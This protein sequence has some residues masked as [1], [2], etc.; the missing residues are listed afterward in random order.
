MIAPEIDPQLSWAKVSYA[1]VRG[2]IETQWQKSDGKVDLQ[3]TIPA[4]TTATV[5]L[6]V[7]SVGSAQE[8]GQPLSRAKGLSVIGFENGIIR[9]E[10]GSGQYQFMLRR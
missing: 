2:P 8:S 9:V 1:S 4:N 5:L 10:V 7:S 3:I 6:P